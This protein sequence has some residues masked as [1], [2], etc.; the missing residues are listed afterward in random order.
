M[1]V[2]MMF[3][4]VVMMAG[5]AFAVL[6][7]QAS[8]SNFDTTMEQAEG[9][10]EGSYIGQAQDEETAA[11]SGTAFDLNVSPFDSLVMDI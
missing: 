4:M 3:L 5:F 10:Y 11:G 8:S 6:P 7:A 1:G 2:F 9:F